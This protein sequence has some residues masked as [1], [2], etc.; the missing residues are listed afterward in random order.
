MRVSEY[1]K[2]IV[3]AVIA[4]LAALQVAM[5]DDASTLVDESV[6]TSNEWIGVAMAVVAA[7]GLVWGVQ[8]S[9]PMP[10]V[11]PVVGPSYRPPVE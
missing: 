7:L 5:M 2:A 9:P 8:N 1:A 11:E 4:G 6:V 3:G 10:S